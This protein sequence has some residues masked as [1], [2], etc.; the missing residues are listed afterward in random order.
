LALDVDV[1]FVKLTIVQ[2][3][4][5]QSTSYTLEDVFTTRNCKTSRA[6]I[7][8]N[9]FLSLTQQVLKGRLI[10]EQYRNDKSL[11]SLSNIDCKIAH[12]CIN[13]TNE[14]SEFKY[15]FNTQV[16]CTIFCV[17]QL[18]TMA[19]RIT[20]MIKRASFSKRVGVPKGYLAV[21]PGDK[22]SPFRIPV[23]YLNQPSFQE[24]LSQAEEEFGYD[25]A[26]GV[27]TIPCNEDEFLNITSHLS[28]Q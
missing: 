28:E 25:Q 20:G 9:L 10:Q 12:W 14:V 7:V 2:R 26:T 4:L 17:E 23:S 3:E 6:V 22:M 27:P 19:F 13:N 15:F 24:L 18:Y 5:T 8:S 21:Y 16:V 1:L 11:H